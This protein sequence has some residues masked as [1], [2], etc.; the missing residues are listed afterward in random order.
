M[1]RQVATSGEILH[2]G[3]ARQP[4]NHFGG[5]AGMGIDPIHIGEGTRGGV[6]IDVD[7]VVPLQPGEAG[8]LHAVALQDDDRFGFGSLIRVLQ[9]RIA[10][11]K[12]AVDAGHAIA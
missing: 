10:E 1:Y 6:V 11:R 4:E 2:A 7:E 5:G 9:H 8:A 12:R 3:F